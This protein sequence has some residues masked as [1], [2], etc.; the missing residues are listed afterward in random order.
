MCFQLT[1]RICPQFPTP[2]PTFEPTA[3]PTAAPTDEPTASP[4]EEPTPSPTAA[5]TDEPTAVRHPL[6][7]RTAL[8]V[9]LS[10]AALAGADLRAHGDTHAWAHSLG[11][12]VRRTYPRSHRCPYRGQTNRRSHGSGSD[13]IGFDLAAPGAHGVP[14]G[15][16]DC[17]THAR[18][19]GGA[20]RGCT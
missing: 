13:L 7:A 3:E 17:D 5:P 12:V 10:N 4:T 19:Y 8:L 15:G 2:S 9:S 20:Y 6:P 16:A 1:S 14:D 11:H 18:A